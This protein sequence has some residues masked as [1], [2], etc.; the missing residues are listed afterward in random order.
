MQQNFASQ[1]AITGAITDLGRQQADCCCENRLATCQTQ[2]IVQNE[3]NQTRFADANNT[4]DI[5][6]NQTANT[7]AILDKLCQKEINA[8]DDIIANLRSQLNTQSLASQILADNSRQ[9]AVLEDYLN[10]T[11]RPAYIVQNPNCCPTQ[12]NCGIN[13]GCGVA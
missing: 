9:T 12:N 3:G 1:T 13:C 8:K 10:P 7:Q 2:N 4:R 5:I 6:T 11:A